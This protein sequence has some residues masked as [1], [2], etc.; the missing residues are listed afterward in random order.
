MIIRNRYQ[1][2]VET[3]ESR[4][5]DYQYIYDAFKRNNPSVTRFVTND[6]LF[7]PLPYHLQQNM[8]WNHHSV[9]TNNTFILL[10]F[11]TYR[12]ELNRRNLIRQYVKQ[13]MIVDGM[14]LNYIMVVACDANE[15]DD[16]ERLRKENSQYGDL[17]I[18][19]HEDKCAYWPITVLD[20]FV[21]AR[22][23]CIQASYICKVDCDTWVHLG[24]MVRYLRGAPRKNYYGGMAVHHW[25]RGGQEYKGVRFIPT[26]YQDRRIS[27]NLGACNVLSNDVVP[28]I[29]IGTQFV[30]I[31]FPACEDVLISQILS[32]AGIYPYG[33]PRGYVWM[34]FSNKLKNLT[35]S[36]N[37]ISVHV[38]GFNSL[39]E[40]YRKY[41]CNY[42]VPF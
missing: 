9:C 27:F 37:T 36:P 17:L 3:L 40:L 8:Q 38:S 2:S 16:M 7:S 19:M 30:D 26:D 32:K 12:N 28:F 4:R 15:N 5:R 20:S 13:G 41:A 6:T 14:T 21:W 18:S 29:G 24:K 10:M 42:T 31:L 1:C 25:F 33:K 34:A 35:V 39:Q 22:D 23:Y 11:F